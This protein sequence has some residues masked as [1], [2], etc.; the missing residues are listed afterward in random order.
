MVPPV[1]LLLM[2]MVLLRVGVLGAL[3]LVLVLP[4]LPV[5]PVLLLLLLLL[6]LLPPLRGRRRGHCR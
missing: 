6:L 5:L 1:V 2:T 3:L 4:V